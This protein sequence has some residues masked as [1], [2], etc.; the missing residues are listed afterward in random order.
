MSHNVIIYTSVI[1]YMCS[2]S[3]DA[4]EESKKLTRTVYMVYTL[5]T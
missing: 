1:V 3:F 2:R 5:D 4:L